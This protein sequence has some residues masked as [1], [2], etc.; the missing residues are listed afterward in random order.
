MKSLGD[1]QPLIITENS[2]VAS[3]MNPMHRAVEFIV[4]IDREHP[5]FL[6]LSCTAGQR[7]SEAFIPSARF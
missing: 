1:R 7:T 4:S 2:Q 6:D 5:P 3:S